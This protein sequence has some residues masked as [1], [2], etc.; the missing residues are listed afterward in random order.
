MTARREVE[1]RVH[2]PE[3]KGN[4]VSDVLA[5]LRDRQL[6]TFTR[7]CCAESRGMMML[8]TTSRP[9]EVLKALE[10]AGYACD[11]QPV[12]LLG[13]TPYQPGKTA[14]LMTELG[15]QGVGIRYS[16]LSSVDPERCFMVLGTPDCER[17][18][19]LCGEPVDPAKKH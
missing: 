8:L 18:L 6:P 14:Q 5:L 7:S 10:D 9:E 12:V 19:A 3:G 4:G 15:R 2:I 11:L 16:Y 1:I 13:P 17:V